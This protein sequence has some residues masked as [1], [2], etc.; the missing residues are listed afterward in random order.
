MVK[1]DTLYYSN[2]LRQVHKKNEWKFY[3]LARQDDENDTFYFFYP[4][5]EIAV[6]QV[7]KWHKFKGTQIRYHQSGAVARRGYFKHHKPFRFTTFFTQEGIWMRSEYYNGRGEKKAVLYLSDYPDTLIAE[8][9]NPAY[10]GSSR[11]IQ[12]SF[13]A[14]STYISD[15][16]IRPNVTDDLIDV[17]VTLHFYISAEGKVENVEII[18]ALHP[19]IDTEIIRIVKG[20]PLWKPASFKGRNWASEFS[21]TVNL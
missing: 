12:R 8:C 2:E 3:R 15:R 18:R 9:R 13:V 20:M 19:Q 16:F 7:V 14:V 4:T 21:I 17:F 6:K 11:S 5:H 10:F 1:N